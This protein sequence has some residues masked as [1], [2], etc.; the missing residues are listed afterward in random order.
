VSPAVL[1]DCKS[2]WVDGRDFPMIYRL[3]G[4]Q[5]QGVLLEASADDV[6]R[7]DFYEGPFSYDLELVQ[8]LCDGALI[9][10]QTYFPTAGQYEH[11]ADWDIAD[12]THRHGALR[13]IAASEIMSRFG[14]LTADQVDQR[15][16]VILARAQQQLN[17][18]QFPSSR[19]LRVGNDAQGVDIKRQTVE[20][21]NWFVLEEIDLT[22]PRYDGSQSREV[23]RAVFVQA[24]AVTVL[25]Y[26]P[27]HDTVML[28]EQF[29]AGA[30]RRGDPHP[31]S[32]EVIAGRIDG[33]ETS[34][35]AAHREAFEE[36]GLTI[37]ELV[38]AHSY[39]ASPGATTEHLTSFIGLT[40]LSG[41]MGG[42]SG[43]ETEDEDIRSIVVP[44]ERLMQAVES[45]EAENAPLLISALWLAANRSRLISNG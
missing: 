37:R 10:A 11:G 27:V 6:A 43:L 30:F 19:E 29:R 28:I 14:V 17:A 36:T 32:L 3:K 44:F 34:E 4:A 12:W 35:Q 39:Y 9:E 41:V 24:D 7:M 31:W 1:P 38:R 5:A 16:P 33:G 18:K 20:H 2:A 45:G 23:K 8:V 40:D 42:T 21:D 13:K 15:Y 26:D 22:H 25:P